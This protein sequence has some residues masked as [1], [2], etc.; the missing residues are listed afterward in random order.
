MYISTFVN[1]IYHGWTLYRYASDNTIDLHDQREMRQGGS[2]GL[3]TYW[4]N[5]ATAKNN[6]CYANVC[7]SVNPTEIDANYWDFVQFA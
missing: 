1:N 4:S 7:D 5:S 2:E 3:L 6:K